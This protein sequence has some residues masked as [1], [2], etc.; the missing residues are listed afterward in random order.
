MRRSAI[1]MLIAAAFSACSLGSVPRILGAPEPSTA[2]AATTPLDDLLPTLAD[3]LIA[4]EPAD[5]APTPAGYAYARA[6]LALLDGAV[7]EAAALL[8]RAAQLAPRDAA[9]PAT[10]AEVRLALGERQRAAEAFARAIELGN[11]SPRVL[12][13]AA[14]DANAERRWAHSSR[15]LA[16]ALADE[17]VDP[18]LERLL[19]ASL[20]TA[21][22]RQGYS[23]AAATAAMEVLRERSPEPTQYAAQLQALERQSPALWAQTAGMFLRAGRHEEA[24]AAW[25]RASEGL[26]A[27]GLFAGRIARSELAAGNE[28]AAAEV[29]ADSLNDA[30]AALDDDLLAL[31]ASIT[32]TANRRVIAD[33][34]ARARSEHPL[35][36]SA[37]L[38]SWLWRLEAEVS[39]DPVSLLRDRLDADP[40]DLRS[41]QDMLARLPADV[42]AK[43]AADIAEAHPA[44]LVVLGEALTTAHPDPSPLLT[45]LDGVENDAASMLSIRIL[46]AYERE[47][48][49]AT[50]LAASR[51]DSSAAWQATAAVT[52]AAAGEFEAAIRAAESIDQAEAPHYAI[53]ALTAAGSR[54]AALAVATDAAPVGAI[55]V[56]RLAKAG[57]AVRFGTPATETILLDLLRADPLD[58]DAASALFSVYANAGETGAARAA[59]IVEQLN[60]IAPSATQTRL[61]AARSVAAEQPA[62]AERLLML[63]FER[64][65]SRSGVL[66]DL[67]SLWAANDPANALRTGRAWLEG[68]LERGEP[69]TALVR[70][71]ARVRAMLG[72]RAGSRSLL[73]KHASRPDASRALEAILL[74]DPQTRDE[75]FA[76]RERRLAVRGGGVAARIE[77]LTAAAQSPDAPAGPALDGV[78]S[79]PPSFELLPV[80]RVPL[81]EALARLSARIAA[82]PDAADVAATLDAIA[83]ASQRFGGLPQQLSQLRVPLLALRE[84]FDADRI[85]T[86][87][88]ELGTGAWAAI[89]ETLFRLN[90]LERFDRVLAL[91]DRLTQAEASPDALGQLAIAICEVGTIDHAE[92]WLALMPEAEDRARALAALGVSAFEQA[93]AQP[94]DRLGATLLNLLAVRMQTL[95]RDR[96]AVS[97][98][99][100]AQELAPDDAV[101]ANNLAYS[102]AELGLDLPRAAALAERVVG[103]EPENASFV[104]TLGWVRYRQGRFAQALELLERAESL[105]PPSLETARQIGDTLWQLGRRTEAVSNWQR[106]LE[107]ANTEVEG[108]ADA[109]AARRAALARTRDAVAARLEAVE[110]G[111]PP[112]VPA[113]V[114]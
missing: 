10:L 56:A 59:S 71:T 20:A 29:I 104:D 27:S 7:E 91:G 81:L 26:D 1:A 92:R 112:P 6:R 24:V 99:S 100:R 109:P 5:P 50:R 4:P 31:A 75:G 49:A 33:A 83:W 34:A 58:P 98:L 16:F 96:Q 76:L 46:L 88:R 9:I 12:L 14:I 103:L 53:E 63:A 57:L 37:H 21:L 114:R 38:Q 42:A 66:D 61:A 86:D 68:M 106:A 101:L 84:P 52:L 78:R 108:A 113:P 69:G 48:E 8:E 72:D 65:P 45:A 67:I 17:R 94:P 74:A 35:A 111:D 77:R 105:G 90:A 82:E 44:A 15:L 43:A 79:I 19:N 30:R 41:A 11:R 110:R 73:Q 28:A 64:A 102:L 93:A 2:P 95:G 54:A 62:E 87:A 18:G 36:G 107:L 40:F 51:V 13:A 60:R 89:A 25:R 3:G 80:E 70:A 55:R 47:R 39:D 85:A 23:L 97:V 22:D 32:D